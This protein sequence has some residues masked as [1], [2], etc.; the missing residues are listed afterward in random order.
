MAMQVAIGYSCTAIFLFLSDFE[1]PF[2]A[3][4]A[5]NRSFGGQRV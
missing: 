3:G 5:S 1:L 4:G 2:S